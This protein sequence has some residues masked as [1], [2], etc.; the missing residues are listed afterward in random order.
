MTVPSGETELKRSLE[1]VA[2]LAL[3]QEMTIPPGKIE[4]RWSFEDVATIT[5]TQEMTIPP[6]ET[7]LKWSLKAVAQLALSQ[8]MTIPPGETELQ[9]GGV[10]S[11]ATT[12][13]I[14]YIQARVRFCVR[15]RHL[16][17]ESGVRVE[18][19]SMVQCCFM[20]TETIQTIRDGKPRTATSTFTPPLSS[21]Y[22]VR[23]FEFNVALRPQ[24]PYRLGDGKPRA[25]TST[26][27]RTAPELSV[28]VK[29]YTW[30]EGH[31]G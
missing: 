28:W 2:Q 18:V 21:E 10:S 26:F 27:T 20:S 15:C 4:L 19:C 31:W 25:A 7:E 14:T 1:D 12:T 16:A 6:G 5:V 17:V 8:E 3:S 13:R 22:R 11:S 23:E 9:G 24:R 29:S 30:P